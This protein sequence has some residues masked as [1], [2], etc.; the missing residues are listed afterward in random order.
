M[1]KERLIR[2]IS[3]LIIKKI[4]NT[5]SSEE[6]T[7]LNRWRTS[8]AENE[9]LFQ[10]ILSSDDSRQAYRYYREI[11]KLNDWEEI[12]QK[13][14]CKRTPVWKRLMRYAAILL[15]GVG[16]IGAIMRMISDEPT[17][18]FAQ[19]EIEPGCLKA[20]LTFADGE[21]M[22]LGANHSHDLQVLEEYGISV[23][24][25]TLIYNEVDRIDEYHTLEV[26]RGGEYILTL[27]DGTKVWIN[28]ETII[29]F[30]TRFKQNERKVLLLGGEAYFRVCKDVERPFYVECKD[31]SIKVTGTEFNV[32]AYPEK[33]RIET[34]LVNGGVK[35]YKE[36]QE[37]SLTPQE[38]AIYSQ[39]DNK[40]SKKKVDVKYFTSWKDGVFEFREMPLGDVVVQLERWYNVNFTFQ[41]DSL[42]QILF[43]GAIIKNKSLKFILNIIKETQLIDYSITEDTVII[44]K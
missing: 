41:D 4:N 18:Q 28:A 1:E 16:C 14:A 15:V 10:M 26:P 38:Q 7:V 9:E 25:S 8:N 35:I 43:T 33:K 39:T 32:M 31:I 44:K 37:L 5:I 27:E 2:Q 19:E 11:K 3:K 29:K 13:L 24:D 21:K 36:K 6:E 12:K 23:N 42:K 17:V 20:V 22:M 34:T 40:L 30:P